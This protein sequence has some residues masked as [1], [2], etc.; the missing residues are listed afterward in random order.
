MTHCPYCKAKGFEGPYDTT[1]EC[2]T[3]SPKDWHTERSDKCRE[4]ELR[5]QHGGNPV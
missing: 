1:Y 5:L 2:G 4:A 3:V